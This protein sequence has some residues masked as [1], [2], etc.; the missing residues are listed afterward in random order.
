M[1]DLPRGIFLQ[2]SILVSC[3]TDNL[4]HFVIPVYNEK[5]HEI[6]YIKPKIGRET[7]RV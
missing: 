1:T 7:Y 4:E 3:Y 5:I 6:R 2:Y